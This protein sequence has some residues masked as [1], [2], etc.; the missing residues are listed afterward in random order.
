MTRLLLFLLDERKSTIHGDV[1]CLI[2]TDKYVRFKIGAV[3]KDQLL[4]NRVRFIGGSIIV[5]F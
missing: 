5:V 2:I 4:D 1:G 3:L